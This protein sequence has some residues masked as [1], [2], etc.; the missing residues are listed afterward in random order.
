MMLRIGVIALCLAGLQAAWAGPKPGRPLPADF[1]GTWRIVAWVGE[2]QGG[3]SGPDPRGLIGRT[4]R[5]TP[6]E[7]EGPDRTCHLQN[8]EVAVLP[9]NEIETTLWGGQ[10]IRELRLSRTDIGRSFG[11]E[12]TPVFQDRTFCVTAVM[13][14]RDHILDAL[15]TGVI[16]RLARTAD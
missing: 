11:T 2:G 1:I 3:F 4:V 12:R 5:I 13:V 10:R 15:G 9:N 14:D 8:A 7:L 6:T 16:Y